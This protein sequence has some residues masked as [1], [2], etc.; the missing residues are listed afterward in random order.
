VREV[1]VEGSRKARAVAQDTMARVRAA[2]K[3]DY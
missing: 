3:L 1:L 2:V